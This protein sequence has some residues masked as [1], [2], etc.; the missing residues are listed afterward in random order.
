MEKYQEVERSIIKKYRKPIWDRFIGAVKD[1]QMIRPGDKIAVCISGGKDSVLLACCMQH[2]LKYTEVPF[3]LQFLAMDPGYNAQNRA[4]LLQNCELL[5]IPVQLFES[6][7]FRVTAKDTKSPCYLCA[8]MRR[9]YLYRYAQELGCNK[10]ALGH[11][12]DDVIETILMSMLYGAEMRTMM[13]KL[14]SKN[15]AGMELIRPLYYVRERDI[16]AWK[17]YNSLQ[18]LQC[19]CRFT[20][21]GAHKP[22]GGGKRAEVKA[23]I[24]ALRRENPQVDT[25]IFRSAQGVNLD[26]VLSWRQN[27][28]VHSFL[29]TYDK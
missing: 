5:H 17:H 27:G 3:S 6:D 10:I 19:A 1:C 8:R 13:P 9:G 26:T 21:E 25:N 20:E 18:F 12:F 24:A 15:F 29:D 11:H 22:N 23:L 7:I 2:L 14:H 28:Q 4:L 16:I